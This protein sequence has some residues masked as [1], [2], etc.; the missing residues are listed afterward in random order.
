M[1]NKI[2][3]SICCAT[4]NQVNYIAAALDS[5]IAQERE[6]LEFEIIIHDDCSTDG[7]IKIL[8]E[9]EKKYDNIA[10]I[11]EKTNQFSKGKK[12]I[13][14]LAAQAKGEYFAFCE[15]DDF[16]NDN[17]KILK[18]YEIMKSNKNYSLC[19]CKHHIIDKNTNIIRTDNNFRGNQIIPFQDFVLKDGNFIATCSVFCKTV[20]I[21]Q[22]P[23]A[24]KNCKVGDFP[25]QLFLAE[26]G[27]C[28]FLDDPCCSYRVHSVGSL[29]DQNIQS[30][31]KMIDLKT[32]LIFT[33]ESFNTLYHNKY[34]ILFNKRIRME[35]MDICVIK[36]DF[37][38]IKENYADIYKE[39]P[40]KQK[41]KIIIKCY[42]PIL[43]RLYK[44]CKIKY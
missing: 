37:R 16:W 27:L 15:G 28:Y 25:M 24:Y 19:V 18:Q 44:K 7:T 22:L 9:Y 6:E 42:F 14:I 36:R 20:D 30:K 33:C 38:A 1:K 13:P 32:N 41:V 3:V 23:L 10:V 39:L 4:F 11:Y 40:N 8:N 43:E 31:K 35:K 26:K 21:Q 12:L 5:F 17:R 29:T 2:D 34:E